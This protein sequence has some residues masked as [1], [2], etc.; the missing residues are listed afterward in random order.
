MF[1][2]WHSS[3]YSPTNQNWGHWSTPHLDAL[4]QQA[5][6]TFDPAVRD[7]ILA[8]AHALAIDE[9]PWVWIGH[10]LTPRAMSAKVEGFHPAQSWSQ[11]FTSITME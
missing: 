7:R 3:S 9:A 2:Y 10:D 4:L 8:E 5:Q 6:E 11:D 1:R